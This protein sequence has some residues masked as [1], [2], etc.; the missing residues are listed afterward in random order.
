MII[1][2]SSVLDSI[3]NQLEAAGL[4]KEAYKIDVLSNTFDIEYDRIEKQLEDAYRRHA[5]QNQIDHLETELAKLV[6]EEDTNVSEEDMTGDFPAT[7]EGYIL[8][9]ELRGLY[10][11]YLNADM[12][13]YSRQEL[14]DIM[15]G[16]VEGA[17]DNIHDQVAKKGLTD[18][19]I[20]EAAKDAYERF[21]DLRNRRSNPNRL[22][23]TPE[24]ALKNLNRIRGKSLVKQ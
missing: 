14:I 22:N 6:S 11:K 3:A 1:K 2:I 17:G 13:P 8:D 20:L 24:E 10:Q 21:M 15:R 19:Q 23:R 7:S 12:T 9:E 4:L 18:T 16:A 5:P